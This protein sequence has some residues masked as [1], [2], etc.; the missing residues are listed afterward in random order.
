MAPQPRGAV[1]PARDERAAVGVHRHRPGFGVVGPQHAHGLARRG[2]PDM[3]GAVVHHGDHPAAVGR[4][5]HLPHLPRRA[6]EHRSQGAG[7]GV[8]EPHRV[9]RRRRRQHAAGRRDG[10]PVHGAGVPLEPHRLAARGDIPRSRDP[11]FA[12]REQPTAIGRKSRAEH[13]TAVLERGRRGRAGLREA[14]DPRGAILA[15]RGQPRA[16]SIGVDGIDAPRM[17]RDDTD[18]FSAACRRPDDDRARIACRRQPS[19]IGQKADVIDLHAIVA[20][21][22]WFRAA[23]EAPEP[24]ARRR[25][26][27]HAGAVRRPGGRPH[28]FSAPEPRLPA[29]L[30]G[31][32]PRTPIGRPRCQPLPVGTC[33]HRPHGGFVSAPRLFQSTRVDVP[34]PQ[35][36]VVGSGDD[37]AAVGREGGGVGLERMRERG[38]GAGGGDVPD[39][40]RAILRRAGQPVAARREDDAKRPLRVS[41][42]RAARLSRRRI[43]QPHAAIP[44]GRGQQ[45]AIGGESHRV[46]RARLTRDDARLVA[47]GRI[48]E[49]HRAVAT[50]RGEPPAIGREIDAVD[51]ALVAGEAEHFFTG[52]R[53][54]H[55]RRRIRGTGG[56][57]PPVGRKVERPQGRGVP[58]E[59]DRRCRTRDALARRRPEP[60]CAVVCG[61]CET[62]TIGRPCHRPHGALVTGA[63]GR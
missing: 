8:P 61:G 42:T 60:R 56:H 30:G 54:P 43:P 33:R 49:S 37:T 40:H 41:D 7:G 6:R 5:G 19:A 46:D 13:A 63:D 52:R 39:A 3:G 18:I 38:H 11:V 59:H 14:P 20:Q 32:Q 29:G 51:D 15:G 34:P 9:V 48:P 58:R 50:T 24:H 12:G 25:A 36:P 35:Q 53:V 31:P 47:G 1:P 4:E 17:G 57:P 10:D 28:L 21:S 55:P 22:A 26:D 2:I 45:P 62:R 27:R 44:P 16:A 23:V